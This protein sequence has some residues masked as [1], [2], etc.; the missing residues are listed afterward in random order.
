MTVLELVTHRPIPEKA[1]LIVSST[2]LTAR[3]HLKCQAL[4]A[5]RRSGWSGSCRRR[6]NSTNKKSLKTSPSRL[7]CL[8]R[9]LMRLG[10]LVLSYLLAVSKMRLDRLL[11]SQIAK[12][13]LWGL[14]MHHF[15]K[16]LKCSHRV[17]RFRMRLNRVFGKKK[18]P[19]KNRS[20]R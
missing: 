12:L 4:S 14:G 5:I 8:K 3:L 15:K 1:L 6:R 17:N 20:Q 19:L 13:T 18:W 2:M 9:M 7:Y 10:N 11:K 16:N